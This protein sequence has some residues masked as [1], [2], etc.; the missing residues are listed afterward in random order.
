MPTPGRSTWWN[1]NL[2]I[3]RVLTCPPEGLAIMAV[4][5]Y[6]AT[7]RIA[8]PK[9]ELY[10][11]GIAI[12]GIVF[13]LHAGSMFLGFIPEA[14]DTLMTILRAAAVGTL[15]TSSY[16]LLSVPAGIVWNAIRSIL[17]TIGRILSWPFRRSRIVQ[18]ERAQLQERKRFE[19]E[20]QRLATER[21]TQ[22]N[23]EAEIQ[24]RRLIARHSC[25]SF[26]FTHAPLLQHRF[27]TS[28][29]AG[30]LNRLLGSELPVE[31]VESRA[32][33]LLAT[34]KELVA[35][36]QNVVRVDAIT[37][38]VNEYERRKKEI[39]AMPTDAEVK[40]TILYQL[41]LNLLTQLQEKATL[42]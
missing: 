40:E 39:E 34:M 10:R 13:L 33:D 4:V 7:K 35:A 24:K 27:P 22:K 17:T 30:A 2:F 38:L 18:L 29:F 1:D 31:V 14:D 41:K 36:D 19:L 9:S 5:A 8:T 12:G 37:L 11:R 16:W 20:S 3:Y 25:E 42:S 15:V 23:Q 32:V 28:E 26:H 6:F 21:T